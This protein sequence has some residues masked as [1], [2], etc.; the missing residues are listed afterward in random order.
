MHPS[1][2]P[3]AYKCRMKRVFPLTICASLLLIAGCVQP[4]EVA[5]APT[6]TS[7]P[8]MPTVVAAAPTAT[9]APTAIPTAEPSAAPTATAT[10]VPST[11]TTVPP[12]ATPEPPTATP[13]P[14]AQ[15]NRFT[16]EGLRART[17]G[18]GAIEIV[19]VLEEMPDFTR[20]LA[21]YRSDGLRITA[22]LNQPR[23]DG[24]FPA[25]ILNHGY[26]PLDVYQ[27]GNGTQ[28][29]ADYLAARGFVTLSPDFRSHAGSDDAPNQFR[30]GHVI[31]ALNAVAAVQ[32]LSNVQAGK[33]GM[34]GHSNGGAITA[35]AI[36][37]SDQ[38]GAALIYAPASS[39]IEQDYW[40]RVE[41]AAS[42]G[43]EI[44]VIDWPVKPDEAPDLYTRLS[45]LPYAQYVHAP[46]QMHW[47]T[48][49][50]IVPRL[51]PEDLR[52]ALEAAGKPVEWFE[53]EGQPHSFQGVGNALYLER[54]VEF[55]NR[56]LRP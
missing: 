1:R 33:V 55:F 41:R 16:I 2:C 50:E 39:N 53:Y 19:Q 4:Q 10:T 24:P 13:D 3:A 23:G 30:A 32:T 54:M 20:Y 49:D 9:S 21:A 5:Q 48:A 37:I 26:Y 28:L 44:D 36:T 35:K 51:W 7:V 22:M 45:P 17:Y 14:F 11:A 25:V 27:T 42:R 8:L 34:W 31:D 12:T 38:I 52:N 6:A 18:D 56:T 40:F 29:A 47:G 15:Y 46:V 43:Q